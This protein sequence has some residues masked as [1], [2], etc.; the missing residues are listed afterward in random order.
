MAPLVLVAVVCAIVTTGCD[1][2]TSAALT[3]VTAPTGVLDCPT[4]VFESSTS[5]V[6]VHAPGSPSA[7]AAL[8]LLTVDLGR[9][10]GDP[11]VEAATERQVVYLFT[12]QQGHRL[13][14]VVVAQTAS[15]G[16]FVEQTERC[17]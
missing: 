9:P 7:D 4:E 2:D 12:D 6:D 1:T 11:R 5:D 3:E 17:G 16:W 13:G 8:A 14:R 10:P 15:G